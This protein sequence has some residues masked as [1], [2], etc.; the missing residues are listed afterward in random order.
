MSSCCACGGAKQVN[1]YFPPFL[2]SAFLH[3]LWKTL[4]YCRITLPY[5]RITL[6][7]WAIMVG[8]YV[9]EKY[10]KKT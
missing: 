4:G 2:L 7:Y 5:C 9:S 3:F 10:F 8:Y 1:V 6:P